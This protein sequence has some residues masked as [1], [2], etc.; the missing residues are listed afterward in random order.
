MVW[1]ATASSTA[2]KLVSARPECPPLAVMSP[3]LR[4]AWKAS[5]DARAISP[6]ASPVFRTRIARSV[7]VISAS[8]IVVCASATTTR[9]TAALSAWTMPTVPAA[10]AQRRTKI[11][12]TETMRTELNLV[13]QQLVRADENSIH[14]PRPTTGRAQP[15][16]SA[17]SVATTFAAAPKNAT[18][19]M[20]NYVPGPA[21]LLA[22]CSHVSAANR[23][24]AATALATRVKN[25]IPAMR[26]IFRAISCAPERAGLIVLAISNAEMTSKKD[27]K[28]ATD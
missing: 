22:I 28:N 26:S 3:R 23:A 25:A 13:T 10:A 11:A 19:R 4:F 8:S 15:R 6:S 1:F 16:A 27:T 14:R 18:G 21:F 17:V 7:V 24:I 5:A 9:S 20:T 2:I 12:M